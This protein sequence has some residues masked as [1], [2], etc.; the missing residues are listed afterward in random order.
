[1]EEGQV[2]VD[3]VSRPL[4]RPFLVAATQNP[5]EYEGTYPLPEAQLDRFL[6]KVV[7]PI[8]DRATTS[9]RSCAGTPP[10][11][12]RA[13]SPAPAS[14]A[15]AGPAD[16]A[17]GQA[18]VK[19][20]A[21]LARGRR[22]H[23]RHRPRHPGVAVADP[24]RQPARRHRAAAL[25]PGPGPGSSGRDFVTP[26]DVKALAHATL[27]HRLGLRPG[28]RARGRRRRRRCS[29][30]RSARCRCP[31]DADGDLRPGRRCC[32]LLGLVPVV[33]RP[34]AEHGL[35]LAARWSCCSSLA[36]LAARARGPRRSAFDRRPVGAGAAGRPD[37]R[38]RWW[39]TNTRRRRVR[40]AGARRLAADGRRH[41][42]PAPVGLAPGRP[43][44]AAHAAAARRAAATC[45]RVGVTVRSRGPLGL[46][47]R[48]RTRDVPGAVRSLP[49][50]E[51][52]KHLPVAAG[53]A[54]RAR[55]PRRRCGCAGRARSS[56][57]CASTS[58]AT[59]SAR[60]DWRATARTRNV[61]VR[62]W[63]PE[64][65][66]RV[67]LV[68]DTSRTSAGRVDDV[69]RLDSAMDAALLLAALAARAGDRVDFVAGD[70]RVRA[71]L[72]VGRRPRRRRPAAGRD[73]RPRAGDR[74]GRLGRRWPARSPRLGRQR[75]LVVLLTAAGAVGGRGGPAA[76]AARRSPA[77]TGWCSPRSA[78]RP[79]TGSPRPA[80]TVDEVYDAAAA[81]QVLA[82]ARRTADLLARAS[83]CD[84]VD[85]DAERL[86]PALAD[87]YLHAE[88]AGPA[89]RA[90]GRSCRSPIG[91]IG[92]Q[93]SLEQRQAA[94]RPG[95][96]A[97]RRRC[98]RCGRADGRCGRART[99]RRRRRSLGERCRC[100]SGPRSAA[101]DGVTNASM[102]PLT[103]STT[104]S[105]SATVPAVRPS[106]ASDCGAGQRARARPTTRTAA[107]RRRR[108]RR[109]RSARAARAGGSAPRTGPPRS[110]RI[111]IEPMTARL[112]D[113]VEQQV[114][115]RQA[116][117]AERDAERGHPGVVDPDLGGEVAGGV[118]AVVVLEV[119]VDQLVDL[120]GRQ[121][122]L[123][124]LRVL[125][126][127]PASSPR[128]RR[129]LAAS[130]PEPPPAQ[131]VERRREPLGEERRHA[132]PGADPGAGRR[133][134]GPG[135][136]ARTGRRPATA[137]GRRRADDGQVGGDL[138]V[139]LDQL[140]A[141]GAA[142][143]APAGPAP[144]AAATRARAR[145]RRRRGPRGT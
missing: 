129:T 28:G 97:A 91:R 51:S 78:T 49:P 23:R 33:L 58:A 145:A 71:R 70:R 2:S 9:W 10:A 74:R 82:P 59:T 90:D 86:P 22:L 142:Q 143:P 17:A 87:H 113:V 12:T 131:P 88:G 72:R 64:R 43:R 136:A 21:G 38:R 1:M 120:R 16:I 53:P 55:R 134:C 128:S 62:T 107:A 102:T 15:V 41:R 115:H 103:S 69:P 117:D 84:V 122:A 31:G 133:G 25:R 138:L 3:G 130:V 112:S 116:E 13:T 98:R 127:P 5:V 39:S 7:L 56:T 42:Q 19:R 68:L 114:D 4:P 144:R 36:R 14:R 67:V 118:L 81:E 11:S 52:R 44:A 96:R 34:G 83:A 48:Q 50:F 18:A 92:D 61:V 24:G 121:Q 29:P 89:L 63:Q 124:D 6:L 99:R 8:P 135:P 75:A 85:A 65:D 123:L 46:A 30:P 106:R 140:V 40:G 126:Q 111:M 60:I 73:G 27:V 108:R 110:C 77:T 93:R 141:L 66:R 20:G 95:P 37:R 125:E 137:S 35:A 79:S 54:A 47:A 101:P 94:W 80:S 32:S 105:P 109:R 57:R 26:D 139:A 45:G 100:R 132:A 76:G 119:V 104:T